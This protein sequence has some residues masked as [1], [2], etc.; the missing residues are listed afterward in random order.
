MDMLTTKEAAEFL[1]L[2]PAT[3]QNWRVNGKGPKYYKPSGIVFYSKEDLID[4]LKSGI[5]E[6]D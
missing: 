6:N 3:M 1:R 2:K 5:V 4:W